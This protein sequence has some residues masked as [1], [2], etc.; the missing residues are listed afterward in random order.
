MQNNVE[1]TWVKGLKCQGSP[2]NLSRFLSFPMSMLQL[3]PPDIGDRPKEPRPSPAARLGPQSLVSGSH[4]R[5]FTGV[6]KMI[7]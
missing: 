4:K 6:L 3:A 1:P 7:F 5:Q 2:D